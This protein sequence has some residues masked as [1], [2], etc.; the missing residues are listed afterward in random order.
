MCSNRAACRCTM[1]VQASSARC[2]A[3][4]TSAP[5]PEQTFTRQ[6]RRKV[7]A[8]MGVQAVPLCSRF[9]IG[10]DT[11][12]RGKLEGA[13]RKLVTGLATLAAIAAGVTM[14]ST[15]SDAAGLPGTGVLNGAAD[16]VAT[17]ENVQLYV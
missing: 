2:C 9:R 13:M 1:H 17:T 12:P 11:I 8:E 6:N 10:R 7:H 14:L 3:A 4:P 5:L 16:S 15:R